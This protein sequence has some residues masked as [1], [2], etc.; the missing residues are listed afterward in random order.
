MDYQMLTPV[1]LPV[2]R[3]GSD[4]LRS[5]EQFLYYEAWCMDENRYDDWLALWEQEM[6]YW[7]PIGNEGELDPKKTVSIIHDNR[8]QVEQRLTRLRGRL[9]YSQQPKSRMIRVL[10]NITILSETTDS[11]IATSTFTLGEFRIGRQEVFIG[12]NT[13][14]LHRRNDQFHM[15]EKKVFLLNNDD[16]LGNLTFLI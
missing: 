13:H 15:S 7:V 9:A 11:V 5:V 10:S 14:V 8:T 4:L 12:R 2:P 16:A 6:A 3:I 1:S